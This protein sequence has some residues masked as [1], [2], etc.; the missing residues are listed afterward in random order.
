M[1]KKDPGHW[2]HAKQQAA[3]QGRHCGPGA[4]PDDCAYAVAIFKKM[5][6]YQPKSGPDAKRHWKPV[7]GKETVSGEQAMTLKR[8]SPKGD[9]AGTTASERLRS[10]MAKAFS[11]YLKAMTTGQPTGEGGAFGDLHPLIG[12]SLD[13][14]VTCQCKDDPCTCGPNKDVVWAK[15]KIAKA[16]GVLVA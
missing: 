16:L 9:V 2:D 12:Q 6:R 10:D 13:R 11:T 4:N 1:E 8:G 5:A 7:K 14:E 3:K 15:E